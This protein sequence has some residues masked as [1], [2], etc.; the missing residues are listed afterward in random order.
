VEALTLF[1]NLI[2][3]GVTVVTLTDEKIY[4]RESINKIP[5]ELI[6]SIVFL[7]RADDESKTKGFRIREKYAQRKIAAAEDGKHSLAWCPP[8]CDF[9][10][11]KYVANKERVQIVRRIFDE[12]LKGNG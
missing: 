2:R 10:N 6:E 5:T 8:W 11:D 7:M 4:S 1:L 12:Y 3:A 9:Q